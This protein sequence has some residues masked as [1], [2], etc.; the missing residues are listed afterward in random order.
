MVE[1]DFNLHVNDFKIHVLFILRSDQ[2]RERDGGRLPPFSK[3][4]LNNV[5][6]S[7]YSFATISLPIK[8]ESPYP[9]LEHI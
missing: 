8:R 4:D 1:Q 5:S 3:N 7:A 9:P 2:A 6:S